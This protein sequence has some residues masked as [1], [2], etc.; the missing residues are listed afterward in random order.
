MRPSSSSGSVPTGTSESSETGDDYSRYEAGPFMLSAGGSLANAVL[1]YQCHGSLSPRRDNAILFPTWFSSTHRQNAW[2]IGPG[3]ALDTDRYFVICVNLLGN[4]LSSSPSNTPAPADGP[5]FPRVTVLDNVR[6]Q[7]RLLA[8]HLGIER[9]AL[10]IGRSMGAQTAFQWAASY[11]TMI[12]RMFALCGSAKTTAHNFVFLESIKAALQLDAAWAGGRYEQPPVAGIRA[13]G[14]AY[15]AWAMSP[16]FYRQGLHLTGGIRSIE[17]YLT[18]NWDRNF[19][20]CDA[21]D[22]LAMLDTWQQAD[23][24]S[25]PRFDGDWLAA[26]RAIR[27]PAVVMPS[28][29]DMYFPPQDSAEAVSRMPRARLEV[30][31]SVWGH[32]AGSPN[33]DPRDIAV[34]RTAIAGL[35][36]SAPT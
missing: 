16:D 27:C 29:T 11:P 23:A 31:E 26:L 13:V 21:N 7:Q 12:E 32:R 1:A 8:E 36:G 3:N 34:V 19:Q 35:L 20:R 9:L 5:G 4:G 10:V 30:I 2:L 28:R 24:G 17:D 14:R 6:L 15:A 22:L 25:D 33:S 18:R